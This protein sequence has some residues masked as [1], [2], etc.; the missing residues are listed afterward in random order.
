MAFGEIAGFDPA[1]DHGFIVPDDGGPRVFVHADELGGQWNVD[2]GTRVRFSSIQGADGPK[3][4]NVAI[5]S[6]PSEHQHRVPTPFDVG[7]N[8]AVGKC[9]EESPILS[10]GGRIVSRSEY[11]EEI[12]DVLI[13]VLPSVTAMQIMEIRS[14]LARRAV[15]RGWV[16]S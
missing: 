6:C 11:V 2:V 10:L 3:A 1:C 7:D 15:K 13:K 5:V 16:A 4:Y 14:E 9:C 12:T 8:T